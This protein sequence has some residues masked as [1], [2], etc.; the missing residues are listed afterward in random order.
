[1]AANLTWQSCQTCN[2]HLHSQF[3]QSC[4]QRISHEILFSAL[5]LF[6]HVQYISVNGKT[7]QTLIMKTTGLVKKST[8]LQL[9]S[10]VN[11]MET[12]EVE[13]TAS[14][15][16]LVICWST[17]LPLTRPE[18][19]AEENKKVLIAL[20]FFLS[21]SLTL[22]G[23]LFYTG[24]WLFKT[25]FANIMIKGKNIS[26]KICHFV[27]F[28]FFMWWYSVIL[29]SWHPESPCHLLILW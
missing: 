9:D 26:Q 1:M 2:S 17:G 24:Y 12:N 4:Q 3:A 13:K 27:F 16:C 25:A 6:N 29:C 19:K 21:F 7:P 14:T 15:Q 11:W 10:I 22:A 5:S 20:F 23:I 28:S 18:K 8:I